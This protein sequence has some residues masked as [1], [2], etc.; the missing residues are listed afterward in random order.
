VAGPALSS[1]IF[2]CF[3]KGNEWVCDQNLSFKEKGN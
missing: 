3:I 2:A 1:K